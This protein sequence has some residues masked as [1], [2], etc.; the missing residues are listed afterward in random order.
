MSDNEKMEQIGTCAFCGQE[1]HITTV[2]EVTQQ[3]LDD[4]ATDM[5][6][7][8]E[9]QSAKRKKARQAKIKEFIERKFIKEEMIEFIWHAIEMLE[10]NRIEDFQIKLYKD[11]VCK[12]WVDNDGYLHIRL[13]KTEDD[14]LKA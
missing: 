11:R 12:I 3:Q 10:A 8:A 7:C 14:E 4:M 5:C 1:R 13:K 9:A 2:G 6:L